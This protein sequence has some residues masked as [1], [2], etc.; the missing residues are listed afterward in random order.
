MI[1]E[2]DYSH[3]WV[4]G[5]HLW[6]LLLLHSGMKFA[7]NFLY[8]VNSE[9]VELFSQVHSVFWGNSVK[10]YVPLVPSGTF[11][12]GWTQ[13][14][15]FFC[16]CSLA[17]NVA[18]ERSMPTYWDFSSVSFPSHVVILLHSRAYQLQGSW[19]L[20]PWKWRQC[21]PP[22]HQLIFSWPQ[23]IIYLIASNIRWILFLNVGF[24]KIIRKVH[25][26]QI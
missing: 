4:C 18:K 25:I 6:C 2:V 19:D 14:L 22:K 1:D 21:D 15:T 23:S 5:L 11:S 17:G 7:M 12:Y 16:M 20:I 3:H 8:K 24:R 26:P 10:A 9:R 13:L